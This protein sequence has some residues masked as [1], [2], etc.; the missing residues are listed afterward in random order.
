MF[1]NSMGHSPGH[2]SRAMRGVTTTDM[3]YCWQ[4]V[5]RIMAASLSNV[6]SI[7]LLSKNRVKVISKTLSSTLQPERI[8]YHSVIRR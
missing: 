1:V 3:G 5:A 4:R 7:I 6:E 2:S 8:T